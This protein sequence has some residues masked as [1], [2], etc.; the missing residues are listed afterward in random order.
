M[1]SLIERVLRNEK[2]KRDGMVETTYPD[3]ETEIN[4]EMDKIWKEA[5][6]KGIYDPGSIYS[7]YSTEIDEYISRL[8]EAYSELEISPESFYR[9]LDLIREDYFG[10]LSIRTI[11]TLMVDLREKTKQWAKATIDYYDSDDFEGMY[12]E[13]LGEIIR[14]TGFELLIDMIADEGIPGV[15]TSGIIDAE[16]SKIIDTVYDQLVEYAVRFESAYGVDTSVSIGSVQFGEQEE[17]TEEGLDIEVLENM[18]FT[19][20]DL[21]STGSI[22]LVFYLGGGLYVPLYKEDI[23]EIIGRD[24]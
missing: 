20:Y 13:V 16:L 5:E 9:I 18:G 6:S 1:K 21:R 19:P 3:L 8:F 7:E 12:L 4:I 22:N 23:E 2:E 11:D 15:S 17:E 24:L 10:G 14:D